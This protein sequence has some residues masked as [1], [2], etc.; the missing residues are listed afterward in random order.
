MLDGSKL[1]PAAITASPAPAKNAP[2]PIPIIDFEATVSPG[3]TLCPTCP[4]AYKAAAKPNIA[5]TTLDGEAIIKAAAIKPIA[6][7]TAANDILALS[8]FVACAFSAAAKEP[9]VTVK[10]AFCIDNA[11]VTAL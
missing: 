9:V 3:P 6:I 8:P 10:I 1:N 4:I 7:A 5:N 2:T 11:I